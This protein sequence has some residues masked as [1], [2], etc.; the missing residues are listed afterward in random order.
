ME[1]TTHRLHIRPIEEQDREQI[2]DLLTDEVVGR[3]Y[4]LPQYESREEDLP[5][6][7]RLMELSRNPQ[8]Y[9]AGICL[10][11]KLIGIVNDTEI[12]DRQIEMGYA[13]LPAYHNRGY[14][15]EAFRSVIAYLLE[16]GFT[17]VIAGAFMENIAS[18]RVMEKCQMK[19]LPHTDT[20]EY[21]GQT[22]TC[23]YYAATKA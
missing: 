16:N 13:L 22:H 14:A 21:R 1:L 15:T 10:D 12:R 6:F 11:G 7:R 18:I 5:L 3:T 4:M 8:R 20:V 17:Q 19:R 9:V 2:L 23:V